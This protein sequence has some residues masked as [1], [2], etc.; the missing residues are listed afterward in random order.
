MSTKS[1]VAACPIEL[2]AELSPDPKGP[3]YLL[4]GTKYGFC[5]NS[6]PRDL[7]QYSPCGHLGL[8]RPTLKHPNG[9]GTLASVADSGPACATGPKQHVSYNCGVCRGDV[10]NHKH[11]NKARQTVYNSLACMILKS[12]YRSHAFTPNRKP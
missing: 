2:L 3:K 11:G 1:L 5:S 4:H 8:S 9:E 12:H 10:V 7:R 6:R